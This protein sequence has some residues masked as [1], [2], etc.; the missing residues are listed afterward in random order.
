MGILVK[1]V[2]IGQ[3]QMDVESR[4]PTMLSG[5]FCLKHIV[6]IAEQ[7]KTSYRRFSMAAIL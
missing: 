4:E 5:Y 2:K 6:A 1:I 3:L 7:K